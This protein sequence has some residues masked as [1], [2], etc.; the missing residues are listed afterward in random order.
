[1]ALRELFAEFGVEFDNDAL[2]EGNDSITGMVQGLKALG[3]ALASAA[4]IGGLN[5]MVEEIRAMGDELDKTG[6]QLGIS[7]QDMQEW[8]FA[9]GLAGVD[10]AAFSQ[11]LALLQR[12]ANEAAEGTGSQAEAFAALGVNVRTATGELKDGNTLLIET[13]VALGALENDSERVALSLQ[14]MGRSGRR[15]L[16]LF[17]QGAEGVAAARAELEQLGGGLSQEVIDQTVALT[18]EQLRLETAMT[19]LKAR[20]ALALLP[21]INRFTQAVVGIV[22]GLARMTDGTHV[23]E[24]AMFALG[25]A[26][27][28]LAVKMAAAFAIPIALAAA[29]AL[30]IGVVIL[31]VDDLITLFEGGESVIGEFIDALFGVGTAAEVVRDLKD[32]WEGLTLAIRRAFAVLRGEDPDDIVLSGRAETDP[33]VLQRQ[34][35][36]RAALAGT[37]TRTARDREAGL[38]FEQ[39][40]ARANRIRETEGLG[41]LAV[42]QGGVLRERPADTRARQ[43]Q[44]VT[45]AGQERRRAEVSRG[46]RGDV[47]QNV[48]QGDVNVVLQGVAGQSPRELA[49]TIRNTIRREQGTQLQA[50][51]DALVQEAAGEGE[52]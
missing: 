29:A 32:A 1:M 27:I 16:P 13:G 14:L 18:D 9:A 47:E 50:T 44:A 33:D 22:A 4:V 6:I 46:R 21:T 35:V 45:A 5:S 48:T 19:S 25:V 38:T 11:S 42:D 24:I 40:L 51:L 28:A 20:L 49:E 2:E 43:R 37:V 34:T 31:V 52:E 30:A 3:A 10:A 23:A 36:R 17:T 7:T 39:A 8:R 26:A 15:M 41:A 12:N